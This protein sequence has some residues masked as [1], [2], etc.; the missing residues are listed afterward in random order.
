MVDVFRTLLIVGA[1]SPALQRAVPFLQRAEFEIHRVPAHRQ[2]TELL[3]S[4]Q[5]DLVMVRYPLAELPLSELI[6]A[7]RSTSSLSRNAAVLVV[8][9]SSHLQKARS[10]VGGG[11]DRVVNLDDPGD[12]VLHAVAEAVEISPRKT[13]RLM[14]QIDLLVHLDSRTAVVMTENIST[15]GMLVKCDSHDYP[16]GS[17][18]RFELGLPDGSAPIPG[19]AEV[20]RHASSAEEH[21]DGIGVR[22]LA[23]SSDGLRRLEAF[24]ARGLKST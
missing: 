5:F 19:E 13:L 15:A 2:A 14:V 8:T 4:T 10:F 3:E 22:F 1:E 6:D 12:S 16:I 9:G 21:F 24:V 17:R 23:L 20:I 18:V 7:V 11:V